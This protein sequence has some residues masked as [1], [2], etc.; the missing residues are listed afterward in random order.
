MK[1]SKTDIKEF[2]TGDLV[3]IKQG[4]GRGITG[5]VTSSSPRGLIVNH[6]ILTNEKCV[7]YYNEDAKKTKKLTLEE[8]YMIWMQGRTVKEFM[9]WYRLMS[10][11]VEGIYKKADELG[12]EQ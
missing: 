6:N 12:K 8:E 7:E 1:D 2:Q 3:T 9:E 5:T 10:R 11:A 4:V